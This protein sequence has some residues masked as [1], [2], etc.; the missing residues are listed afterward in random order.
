MFAHISFIFVHQV[1][2]KSFSRLASYVQ[3]LSGLARDRLISDCE[4]IISENQI[5]E[6]VAELKPE[7]IDS[8]SIEPETLKQGKER[9]DETV[10]ADATLLRIVHYL[11]ND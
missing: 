9:F 11:M 6:Q 1:P 5:D 4:R 2:K 3:N 10:Q 7:V 8:T